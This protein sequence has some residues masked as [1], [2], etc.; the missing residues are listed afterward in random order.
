MTPE[1]YVRAGKLIRRAGRLRTLGP[2]V[3][4]HAGH[5]IESVLVL[6]P[7]LGFIVWLAAVT[8]RERRRERREQRA[9]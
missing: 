3:I 7:T 4:A 2:M 9:E 8:W 1:T 6:I 5:W